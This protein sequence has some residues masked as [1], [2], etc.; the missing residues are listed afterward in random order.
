[1]LIAVGL[2]MDAFAVSIGFG[3]CRKEAKFR[4]AFRLAFHTALFQVLMPLAGWF[5]GNFLGKFVSFLSP[6][7]AFGLLAIIGIKMIIESFKKEEDCD[8]LDISKGK[9][10]I[11]ICLATSIDAFAAGLSI[12]LLNIPLVISLSIIGIVTFILT[13]AGVYLG[14]VAGVFLEKWAEIAGGVILILIGLKILLEKLF[15]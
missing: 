3:V 15:F 14:K 7:I 10:L 13:I 8:T 1:M 12:G 9:Q 5:G 4:S 6:W 11:L 2:A